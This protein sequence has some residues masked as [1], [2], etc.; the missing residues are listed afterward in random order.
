MLEVRSVRRRRLL[1]LGGAI[2]ALDLLLMACGRGFSLS[3]EDPGDV[4]GLELGAD[5]SSS[6]E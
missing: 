4:G 1:W 2:C 3:E 5:C 6:C